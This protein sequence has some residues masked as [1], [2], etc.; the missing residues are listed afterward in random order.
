MHSYSQIV[1]TPWGYTSEVPDDWDEV[2]GELMMRKV[3]VQLLF[4]SVQI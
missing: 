1:I 2:M 3:E 4:L